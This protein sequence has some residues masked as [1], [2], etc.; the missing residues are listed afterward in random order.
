MDQR[1]IGAFLKEL[2]KEKGITQEQMAEELV[3]SG[4]TISRCISMGDREQ[5]AGYQLAGRDR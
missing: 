4:R 2:R 3:V 1:K 5:Y